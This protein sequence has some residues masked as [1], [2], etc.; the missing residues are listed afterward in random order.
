V[1]GEGG[2]GWLGLS[3]DTPKF[4]E[5]RSLVGP[6]M[7]TDLK[8][9]PPTPGDDLEAISHQTNPN[10]TVAPAPDGELQDKKG[11]FTAGFYPIQILNFLIA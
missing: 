11:N 10:D 7:I 3:T 1:V 2:V 6:I 8:V 4:L 9:S 5:T